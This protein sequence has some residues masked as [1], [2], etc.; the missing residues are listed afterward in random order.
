MF[1]QVT[2]VR[3]G[4]LDMTLPDWQTIDWRTLPLVL[5]AVLALF[6]FH[7]G[8]PWTLAICAGVGMGLAWV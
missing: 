5:I 6:R 4:L 2:Q 1:G 7:L 8:I 3:Q